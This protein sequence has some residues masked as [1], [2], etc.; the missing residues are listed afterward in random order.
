MSRFVCSKYKLQ[1]ENCKDPNI[2]LITYKTIIKLK[3]ICMK[4]IFKKDYISRKSMIVKIHLETSG[5][6]LETRTWPNTFKKGTKCF[7]LI[8]FSHSK[9]SK[10]AFSKLSW[11]IKF[12]QN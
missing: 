12:I 8:N 11:R 9:S 6:T 1:I 5:A 3:P 10:I 7:Q 4:I 2:A